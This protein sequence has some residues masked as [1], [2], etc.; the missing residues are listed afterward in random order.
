MH[1]AR[2]LLPFLP[3]AL[4]ALLVAGCGGGASLG[5]GDVAVVGSTHVTQQDF[6]AEISIAKQSFTSSHQTF[7]KPGTQ[8]YETIKSQ[9]VGILIQR[10][11]RQE[12]AKNLGV[13]V[14]SKQVQDRLKTIQQQYFG[15]SAKRYQAQLKKQHLT[16]AQVRKDIEAQLI[17]EALFNKVTSDVKVSSDEI[18]AYYLQHSQLYTQPQTRDVRYILVKTKSR[19]D[20][21]YAQLKAGNMQTWCTLAKKYSQDPSN[22]DK[23]GQGS[24]SKGQ[25][26]AAFDKILFAQK[27]N[28]IHPPV[29]DPVQYKAWFVIEPTSVVHPRKAQPLSQVKATIEQTLGQQKKN[30]EM[31][32]WVSGLSKNF[33]GGSKIKYQ[34]GYQ[35]AAAQDPCTATTTSATTT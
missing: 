26:V 5:K 19:A 12:K 2:L 29:Y 17:D 6:D 30:T 4:V 23:C 21:I 34:V 1:K 15:G 32:K 22:K 9:A 14:T 35:P 3:V 10:A 11:E 33:C 27:T 18:H 8:Q 13:K 25:T 24:F 16:D 31:N 28:V 7:P 20:S